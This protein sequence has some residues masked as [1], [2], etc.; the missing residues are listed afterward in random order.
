MPKLIE[1]V[2]YINTMDRPN[3]RSSHTAKTPNLGGVL[4]FVSIIFSSYI[5]HHYDYNHTGY[6]VILG[7]TILFFVGLKD[8]LMM[9]SAQT[10]LFAQIFAVIFI[11][12]NPELY[13]F[14]FESIPNLPELTLP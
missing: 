4:F 3:S 5:I 6:S 1:I 2:R 9:L 8:D 10:K 7:L 12:I 11:L 14:N 13:I